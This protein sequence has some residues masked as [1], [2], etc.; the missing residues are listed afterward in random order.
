MSGLFSIS[1]FHVQQLKLSS[2]QI[3]WGG[4]RFAKVQLHAGFTQVRS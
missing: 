4:E 1:L 2:V 3:L